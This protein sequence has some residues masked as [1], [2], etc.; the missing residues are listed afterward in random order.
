MTRPIS[1]LRQ[2]PSQ[3]G[4]LFFLAQLSFLVLIELLLLPHAACC[5]SRDTHPMQHMDRGSD[6]KTHTQHIVRC[7]KVIAVPTA[8]TSCPIEVASQL[9][10]QLLQSYFYCCFHSWLYLL[11]PTPTSSYSSSSCS[12][13]SYLLL[14][15]LAP[16]S[17]CSYLLLPPPAPSSC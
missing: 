3:G 13:C 4:G 1:Q 10:P 9:L 8:T 6:G 5:S 11:L 14:P 2:S 7:P 16:T 12:S 15:P 17:S